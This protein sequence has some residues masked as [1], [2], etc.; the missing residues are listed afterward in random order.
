MVVIKT[1]K[2]TAK[3]S[4]VTGEVSF[5]DANGELIMKEDAGKRH[6]KKINI[7]GT[8]GFELSQVFDSPEDEA[9]YG[10]GQHQ[11]DEMNYKGKNEELFQYNTKVSIPFVVSTKKYGVL[12][13]N[14]SLTRFG[15]PRP[16]SNINTL[17]LYDKEGKEG[18][19]T[20]TYIDDLN[21]GHEFL[22]RTEETIDYENLTTIEKFPEGFNFQHAKI[23]WMVL[24]KEMKM[25]FI[26]SCATMPVIPNFGLMANCNSINGVQPGTLQLLSFMLLWKKV[27]KS[28]LNSNGYLMEVFHTLV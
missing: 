15:D 6:F 28:T 14:Y 23:T 12:W 16:Y 17:K 13:D 21:K 22:V 3:V 4:T 26:I 19:L 1:D 24:L 25:V 8:E 11:A 27:L 9:L 10:L 5:F 18:G 2:A 20:A 7:D